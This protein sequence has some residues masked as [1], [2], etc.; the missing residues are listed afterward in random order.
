MSG[1]QT[2]PKRMSRA[3][4]AGFLIMGRA[5]GR[6]MAVIAPVILTRIL[7]RDEFG[8]YRQLILL[9]S[10]ISHFAFLGLP[11][12]VLYFYPRLGR[13]LRVSLVVQLSVVLGL[14]GLASAAGLI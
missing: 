3:D 6:A 2:E 5:A 11:V 1:E 7:T 8:T 4:Q 10:I 13:S 14:L 12:S 9:S